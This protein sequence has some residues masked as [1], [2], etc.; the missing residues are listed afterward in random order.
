MVS[1][2][3]PIIYLAFISLGLPDGLLGAA[4]PS[5]YE[6][7][8]A[9]VSGGGLISMIIS[10]GTVVSAL[11]CN[12][13]QR[14]LGTGRSTGISVGMTALALLGF[15]LSRAYWQ[16]CLLAIP[17]GLG[18]GCV[19]AALNNYVALHYKARHMSWLHCMWGIG[20][21]GGPVIMAWALTRASWNL[22]YGIVSGI[23][24]ALTLVLL[25][26][27]R[28]WKEDRA[29]ASEGEAA[30]AS[31][32]S[33][34]ELLRLPGVPQ[35]MACFFC[36][37]ALE[38]T[39][40]MWAASYCTLV[41]GIPAS[42]A[43][44]WGSIFYL[45]VTA[46]RLVSGFITFRVN[47]RNMIRLGQMICAAGILL[48]ALPAGNAALL[49]GLLLLGL[50][51]APIYPAI[52]H[53][54]PLNFGAENSQG[55]IGIQMASAYVGTTLMSPL[56]GLL[57]ETISFAILPAYLAIVLLVMFGMAE[58]LHRRTQPVR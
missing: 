47:D 35:V 46:G 8:G 34:P 33:L 27:L 28:L 40:G 5:M 39:I 6:S 50:G 13:L 10:A 1:L 44:A 23:Q 37:C 7:L 48:V 45:G 16:L 32:R 55:V 12:A 15:S 2:L 57:G 58:W 43:S 49:P 11:S 42:E 18:A 9:S 19:D 4:W 14:R 20:A 41:R 51:C 53:E 25:L 38:V 17:Y 30:G 36:Y 26:T 54:T 31:K 52:I 3:L 56:F 24:I 22:G 21:S 29:G